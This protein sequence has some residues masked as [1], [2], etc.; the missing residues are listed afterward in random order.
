M[1]IK[2]ALKKAF[3]E[4]KS[5]GIMALDLRLLL[6]ADQ[7]FK[8]QIDVLVKGDEE[9]KDPELFFSQVERLK[10]GEPVEYITHQT[11]FL[12]NQFYVDNRVLIPR[13]ETEE[14]VALITERV[15][16]YFD[17]RNYLVVADIG[18]GSGA[19]AITLKEYFPSWLITG[20]DISKDALEVAKINKEKHGANIRLLQGDALRPYMAE[21]MNL[22]IIVSNPP[23][24]TEN[25]YVQNSVKEF[26]PSSALYFKEDD[27]VYLKVFREYKNVMKNQL[28]MFFEISPEL[29][30]YLEKIMK[31]YLSNYSYQFLDDLNGFKRFLIVF[32]KA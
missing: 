30:P 9:L 20:S 7:G 18:T 25:E 28:L 5:A 12:N 24:I 4:G 3:D 14:L 6:M 27:N 8:N 17:P 22:D 32:V 23:Y 31:T 19:I 29:V 11:E 2:D 21:K 1:K 15:S 26:E 13:G 10:K 16:D